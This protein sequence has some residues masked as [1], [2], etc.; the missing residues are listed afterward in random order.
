MQIIN[1][2]YDKS[3]KYL[4]ENNKLAKKVL[5]VIL[6]VEVLEVTL[7]Q[8][9]TTLPD[10]KRGLTLFR[11]DFKALI[12]EA[13]NTEKIVLIELQK[14][15]YIT[16]I[17]RFRNYLGASYMTKPSKGDANP[18]VPKMMVEEK[19]TEYH[20]IYP[21]IAIYILGYNLND[22]PYM[23]VSVNREVVNSV[24]QEKVEVKSFFIDH[25]TH[26]AHIIQVRRLPQRRQTRLEQFFTFFDQSQCI[27]D[28]YI[29]DLKQIPKGFEDIARYLQGPVS[30]EQ[31]RRLL[32]AEDQLDAIFDH[33]E[34]QYLQKIA[35]AEKQIEVAEQ[36]REAAEKQREVAEQIKE[37]LTIK[38]VRQ[39]KKSGA[40]VAEI[41]NETGL[42]QE[43]I[44]KL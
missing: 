16:D 3:F 31:F 12:R 29:L 19:P 14:S 37:V 25:L 15:K 27:S 41:A 42:K 24:N 32:E 9:E 6:D 18:R 5:S 22:L 11:L 13:D 39:M 40:T 20:S 23:A 33:Q 44:E 38:L 34:A 35:E 26:Q 2:I 8:Q 4:M 17:Q 10:E 21:I 30:D 28:H 36:Q 7:S 43:E 1:P